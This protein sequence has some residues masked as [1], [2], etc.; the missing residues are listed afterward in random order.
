MDKV[1]KQI[2]F[3]FSLT[4][5][6]YDKFLLTKL[7]YEK[8]ISPEMLLKFNKLS[9]LL[10]DFEDPIGTVIEA[11]KKIPELVVLNDKISLLHPIKLEVIEEYRNKAILNTIYIEN[12]PDSSTHKS[13]KMIFN[14]IGNILYIS[15]P[16]FPE[17]NI[18]KGFGFIEFDNPLP[19]D[20][21]LARLNGTAPWTDQGYD[22]NL[23]IIKKTQ[24]MSYKQRFQVLKKILCIGF[25]DQEYAIKIQKIPSN[26]TQTQILAYLEIKPCKITYKPG[27]TEAYIVYA[28]NTDKNAILRSQPSIQGRQPTYTEVKF[29]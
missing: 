13:I 27:S 15:L 29:Y 3:Y 25:P 2:K 17:S 24:W 8:Q 21:A 6:S 28:T 12:I 23:S 16:R 4:N 11:C 5:L 18:I 26:C 9:E 14:N 7:L 10:K 20:L 22:K 19:C 1:Y